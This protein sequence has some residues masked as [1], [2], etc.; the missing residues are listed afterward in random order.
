MSAAP[1][2]PRTADLSA[3]LAALADGVVVSVPGLRSAVGV[4]GPDHRAWL[5]RLTSLPVAELPPGGCVRTTLMDGKGKLRADLRVLAS[6]DRP[7]ELLLDLPASHHAALLRVL[8]MYILREKV[9]L[10][11]L[12]ASHRWLAVLGP[13]AA[14]AMA[15][16]NLPRPGPGEVLTARDIA[17]VASSRLYG[18][19]GFD[20]LVAGGAADGVVARLE[21]AGA[22][23]VGPDVLDVARLRAGIPWFAADL[24]D[25]VIP[26]EAGLDEAVSI[27]K[28]CYPGQ[29]VVARILNLGQV[30]RRLVGLVAEG[31]HA[32]AAGAALTGTGERAG[33]DA[34]RI[35]SAAGDPRGPRTLALG[36][37]RRAFWSAGS[38]LSAGGVELTVTAPADARG[39][40]AGAVTDAG[41]VGGRDAGSD[42]GRD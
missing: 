21:A 9:T 19:P 15:A 2:R 13:S 22:R 4:S 28:G 5:D 7:A 17:A 35:T 37:V 26:L 34:G 3:G 18:A 12:A 31:E 33:Q 25:G 29:E 6:A 41:H 27:A 32:L 14:K 30:S 20:L 11:D 24:A 16:V 10:A 23:L 40:E 1:D 8:D 39:A 38:R 36:F 42:A